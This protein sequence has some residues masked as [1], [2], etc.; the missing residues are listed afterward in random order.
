M[1]VRT[2]LLVLVLVLM[3]SSLSKYKFI[4]I[5]YYNLERCFFLLV[6][7]LESLLMMQPAPASWDASEQNKSIMRETRRNRPPGARIEADAP[8][9]YSTLRAGRVTTSS[10]RAETQPGTSG[11]PLDDELSL[12]VE[13]TPP[14][15]HVRPSRKVKE[16]KK[17][18][19]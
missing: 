19:Y 8:P 14:L 4:I 17:Y 6:L 13:P 12:Y 15:L 2:R 11:W 1:K 18:Y 5:Y 7:L 9:S 16:I 3:Q 10:T